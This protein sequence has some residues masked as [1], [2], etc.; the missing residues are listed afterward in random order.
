MSW[1]VKSLATFE[2]GTEPDDILTSLRPPMLSAARSGDE[3]SFIVVTLYAHDG[4]ALIDLAADLSW[5]TSRGSDD[6]QA[7]CEFATQASGVGEDHHSAAN[8]I[9]AE[10]SGST[11]E[12]G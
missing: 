11:T 4:G 12:T 3:A 8:R 2:S 5:L 6:G 9:L 1:V 10:L 7:Q